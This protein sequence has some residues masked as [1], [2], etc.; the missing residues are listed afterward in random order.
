[1]SNPHVRL[2]PTTPDQ[3]LLR[4]GA[5]LD[6]LWEEEDALFAAIGGTED[7]DAREKA[8]TSARS[9]AEASGAVVQEILK[10]DATTSEGLRVKMRALTWCHCG[11]EPDLK[12]ALFE[13]A[14]STDT[15]IV[16]SIIRDLIWML[17]VP[18]NRAA[19]PGMLSEKSELEPVSSA[20]NPPE[21][22]D[23]SCERGNS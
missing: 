19:G 23:C 5:R 17:D 9:A 16:Q 7:Q 8:A 1:M 11:E 20:L 4:L 10:Q 6:K 12:G 14:E 2:D 15:M 18:V 22:Q 13:Q 21:P 3:A